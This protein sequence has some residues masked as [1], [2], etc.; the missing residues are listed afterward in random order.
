[1]KL[2][3]NARSGQRH[4]TTPGYLVLFLPFRHP[5]APVAPRVHLLA[6]NLDTDKISP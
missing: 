3:R 5:P 4:C 2:L 1:M 6:M